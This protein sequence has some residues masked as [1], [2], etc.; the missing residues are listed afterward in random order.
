MIFNDEIW[1][2]YGKVTDMPLDS[3]MVV[4]VGQMPSGQVFIQSYAANDTALQNALQHNL[5]PILTAVTGEEYNFENATLS[6]VYEFATNPTT[7]LK[8]EADGEYHNLT[9]PPPFAGDTKAIYGPTQRELTS[10]PEQE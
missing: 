6:H 3:H 2:T 1:T 7:V 8:G 5:V 10:I 4:K 9:R